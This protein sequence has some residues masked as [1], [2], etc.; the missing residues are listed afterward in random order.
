MLHWVVICSAF[1]FLQ[2]AICVQNKSVLIFCDL[3]KFFCNNLTQ[4]FL[5]LFLC[6][7]GDLLGSMPH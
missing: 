1:F 3:L 2:I 7:C 6:A 5:S 4:N